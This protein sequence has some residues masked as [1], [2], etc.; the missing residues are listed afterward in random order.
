MVWNGL[1]RLS[2]QEAQ[3][4]QGGEVQLNNV[5]DELLQRRIFFV[6]NFVPAFFNFFKLT[7]QKLNDVG[8]LLGCGDGD[9]PNQAM[10]ALIGFCKRVCVVNDAVIERVQSHVLGVATGVQMH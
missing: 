1:P 5:V 7:L 10:T 2:C 6:A 9:G 3:L 8:R 4:V